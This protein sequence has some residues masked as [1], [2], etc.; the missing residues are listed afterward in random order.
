MSESLRHAPARTT[1]RALALAGSLLCAALAA[2]CGPR[3]RVTVLNASREPLT[4][5]RV[6]AEADSTRLPDLAPGASLRARG[7]VHGEDA[8]VL[9]GRIGGRP[10]TPMMAT[11]VEGG[12]RLTMRVDSTGFVQVT[13]PRVPSY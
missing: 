9:R 13:G 1:P 6:A 5:L 10:L 2:G 3:I 8:I 11:Y 7:A 12:Y 4:E